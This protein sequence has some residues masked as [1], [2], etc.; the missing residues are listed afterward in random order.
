MNFSRNTV[1]EA[2]E[3]FEGWT[4]NEFERYLFRFELENIA[5]ASLGSKPTRINALIRYFLENPIL[6]GPRGANII[7]ETIEFLLERRIASGISLA[8]CYPRLTHSL[9]LDGY[10][11]NADGT[12]ASV[13]PASAALASKQNEVENLLLKFNFSVAQGHLTQAHNAHTRGD[14]AAAN[15]QMR[16]FIESLFDAFAEKLLPAPLPATSHLKREGLA[17]LA[18]PFIDPSLNEWDFSQDGGCGFVQGFWKRL[19]PDGSHP[20]LSDEDDC[21]FRLQLVYLVAH[22]FL[23]RFE[24]Y[25]IGG[26]N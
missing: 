24:N 19:H 1:V 10:A 25:Q 17:K 3:L 16:T 14:W 8:D 26:A 23:K 9:R 15:S 2:L 12:L 5:P 13:L 18:P 20:G 4:T 22:R 7:L 11:V 21:T 6:I